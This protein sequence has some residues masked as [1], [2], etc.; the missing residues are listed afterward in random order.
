ML[1]VPLLDP[2]LAVAFM[3]R[4]GELDRHHQ[5]LSAQL[6][7]PLR[8]D[9]EV[10]ISPLHVFALERLLAELGLRGTDRLEVVDR[11]DYAAVEEHLAH[12]I[13]RRMAAALIIDVFED[14]LDHAVILSDA[15]ERPRFIADRRL[16]GW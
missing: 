12:L 8:G 11:V 7:D 3:V 16:A 9:V 2:R 13:A 10:L 6:G 14:V 4:A 15:V 1:P 5:A